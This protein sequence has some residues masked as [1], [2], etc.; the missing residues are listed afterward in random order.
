MMMERIRKSKL[1]VEKNFTPIM[2]EFSLVCTNF[3]VLLALM[4][5]FNT[6]LKMHFLDC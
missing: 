6:V 4:M 3:V 1:K 5:G 2:G